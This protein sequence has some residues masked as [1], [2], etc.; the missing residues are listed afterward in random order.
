[1]EELQGPTLSLQTRGWPRPLG[2][3]GPIG[4][5]FPCMGQ[6]LF[7]SLRNRGCCYALCHLAP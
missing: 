6:A 5:K 3:M 2:M 7:Y 1:M 4:R